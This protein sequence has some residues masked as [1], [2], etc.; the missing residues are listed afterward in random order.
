MADRYPKVPVSS[1]AVWAWDV[2]H[3]LLRWLPST[4]VQSVELNGRARIQEEDQN[5]AENAMDLSLHLIN[6]DL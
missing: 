2:I 1:S 3:F 5:S 4:S 6:L